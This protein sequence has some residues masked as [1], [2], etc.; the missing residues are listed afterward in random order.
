MKR[1]EKSGKSLLNILLSLSLATVTGVVLGILF[2]PSKGKKTRKKLKGKAH[3][4]SEKMDTLK[5]AVNEYVDHKK[6]SKNMV[7]ETNPEDN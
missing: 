6:P 3:D 5:D 2:A 1:S 4:L 7:H